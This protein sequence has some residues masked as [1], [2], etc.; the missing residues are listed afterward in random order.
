MQAVGA[1]HWNLE[2][3]SNQAEKR[4]TCR[5]PSGAVAGAAFPPFV[6]YCD[7]S[8][9]SL[10]DPGF[11]RLRKWGTN[12]WYMLRSDCPTARQ[13]PCYLMKKWRSSC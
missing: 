1:E 7:V 2:D 6:E 3:A 12:E 9:P 13:F 4:S 8:D 11:F 10:A 5:P